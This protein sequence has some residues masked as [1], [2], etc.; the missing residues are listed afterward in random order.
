MENL[1]DLNTFK[2]RFQYYAWMTDPRTVLVSSDRLLQ[3]KQIVEN[4]RAGEQTPKL[5]PEEVKYNLKL[6]SSAFHPDSGE[7]QN[8]AGRMSFQASRVIVSCSHIYI[9]LAICCRHSHSCQIMNCIVSLFFR[10][11]GAC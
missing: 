1:F 5:T 8:F 2:D 3:A 11:L 9:Y 10:C 6:Y 4:Y 7:L